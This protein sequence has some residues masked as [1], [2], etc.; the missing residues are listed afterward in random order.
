MVPDVEA[1]RHVVAT[2]AVWR[3]AVTVARR[4]AWRLLLVVVEVGAIGLV[5]LVA[6]VGVPRPHRLELDVPIRTHARP[7]VRTYARSTVVADVL[8]RLKSMEH[9]RTCMVIS[10]MPANK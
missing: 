4:V 6:L 1:A 9:R 5:D 10:P 7:H 3:A 8:S 2:V